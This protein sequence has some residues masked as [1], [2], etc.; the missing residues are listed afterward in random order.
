MRNLART[1]VATAV[2][3]AG[4][5][6]PAYA[7]LVLPSTGNSTGALTIFDSLNQRSLVVSLNVNY[8]NLLPS[9]IST[10]S[11]ATIANAIAVSD[12][13]E[14]ANFVAAGGTFTWWVSAADSAGLGNFGGRNIMTTG[15][16]GLAPAFTNQGVTQ[17]AN[18]ANNF[19]DRVSTF[20][21]TD[22][23]CFADAAAEDPDDFAAYAGNAWGAQWNGQMPAALANGAAIGTAQ[24]F[25]LFT[26]PESPTAVGPLQAARTAYGNASGFA[27][28]NLIVSGG[29]A[30]LTYTLA[31][32]AVPLPAAA[33]LLI[34]GLLG[35]GTV[36][37]R[38]QAATTVAA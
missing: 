1:A 9:L 16:F 12:Q 17:A 32:A 29:A 10:S 30:A 11:G 14:V 19:Y 35:L 24:G 37:R 7:D 25:Y 28:W 8:S 36:A 2:L 31:N 3:A 20:C 22:D 38:R 34:S 18:A 26:T 13:A 27:S 6:A 5:V 21:G 33:W 15:G 4:A 23:T